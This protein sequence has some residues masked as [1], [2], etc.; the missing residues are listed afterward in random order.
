MLMLSV[1]ILVI[2][3]FL[4]FNASF[5]NKYVNY[6]NVFVCIFGIASI[7]SMF[8][9]YNLYIPPVTAYLYILVTLIC[10][11]F[12]SIFF[13][14]IKQQK[15]KQKK[16]TELNWKY[17]KNLSMI[18]FVSFLLFSIKG[19]S[20]V[21]Q[22]GLFSLREIGFTTELYTSMQKILIVNILKPINTVIL[23]L[24]AIELIQNNKLKLSLVFSLLN[25]IQ[26][27]LIFGGRGVIIEVILYF[28]I[29]LYNKYGFKILKLLKKNKLLV[30]MFFVLIVIVSYM[31]INRSLRGGSGVF[32]NFYN[33]FI[34]SIHLFGVY[35][36]SPC[37]Y[38]LD[39][40]HLL[41]GLEIFNGILE[42][43]KILFNLLGGVQL[44]SGIE[45]INEV[46]QNYVYVAPNVLMNN[47]VTMVYAFLRDFGFFGLIICPLFLAYF[48]AKIYKNKV[49][50]QNNTLR[51]GLWVFVMGELPFLLFEY[52]FAKMATVMVLIFMLLLTSKFF[53]IKD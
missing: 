20:F 19:M 6:L 16:N 22:N 21:A 1:F 52:T 12:F 36:S 40:Q 11:E 47:N 53:C 23:I 46:T 33:Y 3:A 32:Y 27:T 51:M 31:T 48:Y 43:F 5:F 38:L 34:G 18:L 44:K 29:L 42:P 30:L 45:I 17:M 39:N 35:V 41:Y 9:L 15:F 49:L 28:I 25:C 7:F 26:C 14:S 24:S 10:F 2:I 4:V 8:G 37:T 50:D 13:L